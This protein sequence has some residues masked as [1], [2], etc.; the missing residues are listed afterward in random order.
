M[1]A[2]RLDSAMGE[3]VMHYRFSFALVAAC[4]LLTAP[5]AV[6]AEGDAGGGGAAP[7]RIA[8]GERL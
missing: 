7:D 1:L 4:A 6:A 5:P 3:V 8:S 2:S